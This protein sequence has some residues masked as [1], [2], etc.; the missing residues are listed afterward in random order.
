MEA[1]KKLGG[2][3]SYDHNDP[4]ESQTT[5]PGPEWLRSL[6]GEEFFT[7]EVVVSFT[8][9]FVTDADLVHLEGLT[10]LKELYLSGQ[11][12]SDAG[13]KHLRRL[14]ASGPCGADR[15]PRLTFPSVGGRRPPRR[16]LPSSPICEACEIMPCALDTAILSSFDRDR[17]TEENLVW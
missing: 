1:I 7:T 11:Q 17:W 14:A 5:P 4:F 6:L 12:V 10:Q 2:R 3:V 15:C 8:S 16:R 9:G 13:L